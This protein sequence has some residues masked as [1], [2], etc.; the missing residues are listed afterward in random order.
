MRRRAATPPTPASRGSTRWT[1]AGQA[2]LVPLA[3]LAA[4][5]ML[6]QGDQS[7]LAQA[8]TGI[9]HQFG[10]SDQLLGLIPFGMAV[11][12]GIGGIPMGVLA[13]RGRR[14]WLLSAVCAIWAA[15][16]GL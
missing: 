14:T 13:D 10:A 4:T 7:S 2:G 11:C 1:A 16:M 12:G 6:A 9:Q 8:V 15:A 3:A 5:T